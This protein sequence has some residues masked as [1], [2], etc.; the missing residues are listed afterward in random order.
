MVKV[1]RKS[2]CECLPSHGPS[3]AT[4]MSLPP[5][6][7]FIVQVHATYTKLSRIISDVIQCEILLHLC[8]P[9][10]RMRAIK[11]IHVQLGWS[12]LGMLVVSIEVKR[13]AR[14]ALHVFIKIICL[15]YE[16]SS[17]KIE[18]IDQCLRIQPLQGRNLLYI[19]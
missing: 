7:S 9:C 10:G 14:S 17:K 4:L 12:R 2:F 6:P 13:M 5:L 18:K 8:Y 11:F 16:T 15:C 3:V 19:T 1:I